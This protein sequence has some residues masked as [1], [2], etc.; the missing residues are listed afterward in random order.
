MPA[1]GK[2]AFFGVE[3]IKKPE[4]TATPARHRLMA[5]PAAFGNLPLY[6]SEG[7]VLNDELALAGVGSP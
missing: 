2:E 1:L 7:L 5:I 6:S 3:W 4:W